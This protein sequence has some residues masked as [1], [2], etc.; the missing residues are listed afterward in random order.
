MPNFH[1]E[2]AYEA[3]K[4]VGEWLRMKANYDKRYKKHSMEFGLDAE[5]MHTLLLQLAADAEHS[6][7]LFRLFSGGDI[8]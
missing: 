8:T 2:I 5:Q 1:N 3:R 6:E 4:L 7:L